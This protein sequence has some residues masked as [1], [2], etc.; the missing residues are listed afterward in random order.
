MRTPVM[1]TDGELDVIAFLPA[2]LRPVF[3]RMPRP[4][5]ER[6][7]EIRLRVERPVMVVTR[8]NEQLFVGSGGPSTDEA[9]A[10]SFRRSDA[11]EFLQTISRW[12]VYALEEEFRHG[13]L[14][15]PGGHRVGLC[16][17]TALEVGQ[18]RTIKHVGSFNVRI[19]RAVPGVAD[20]VVSKIVGRARRLHHTLIVSPP[21]AGKTT[22]LRDIARQLSTRWKI[23][24]IDERSE[25]AACYNGV[26]QLDVGPRTDVIDRCPKAVGIMQMLRGMSPQVIVTDE[27]GRPDDVTALMEAMHGGVTVVA[28]AHGYSWDEVAARPAF[29]P[30]VGSAAFQLVIVLSHR[31]GPG[32]LEAVYEP[33]N[34]AASRHTRTRPTVHMS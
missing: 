15:L 10:V 9:R 18:P 24:I 16:G 31:H 17:E 29:Q 20:A 30:L 21:G 8:E 7:C 5:L 34:A 13:F 22:L 1:T 4:L 26:P 19:A 2:R 12:S 14:T 28:S 32:T 11:A 27:I 25:I 6:I 33:A 3:E 23:S